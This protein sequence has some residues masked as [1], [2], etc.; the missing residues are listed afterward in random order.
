M[1]QYKNLSPLSLAIVV[2]TALA[3]SNTTKQ[4][5]ETIIP[6]T[7]TSSEFDKYWYAGQAE[8]TR[9]ELEQ[10][11]Y[12]EI[13][14]GD[15]VLIF[16]TEDFD[17]D[18]QVKYEGGKKSKAVKPILKLNFTK[19]FYTG[20]YPYSMMTSIF[21]PINNQPTVKVTTTSQEWCGHTFSQLNLKKNEYKGILHSYFQQ[22]GDQ[23]F[24]L[25]K[26]LLEDEIWSKIRLNPNTLPTGDIEIIPGTQFLRLRH[27]DH[28]VAKAK[29][30]LTD[31][32]DAD[33]SNQ[34]LQ[35]YQI[36]YTDLNRVLKIT[37]EKSFPH[38]IVAWEEEV[39][40]GFGNA[41]KLTTR[42]TRTHTIKSPYWNKHTV[43]DAALRQAL[44]L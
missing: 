27:I 31:F 26:V 44:G 14:K 1:K 17:T 11:R 35:Q 16:V 10:A 3:W 32:A 42:A 23:S 5:Q 41:K 18:K 34:P 40:S 20:L 9:Y 43:A 6:K 36:S 8:L 33:L 30:S 39:L 29:A 37:F 2:I 15:A 28:T 19:K 38:A 25:K 24:A 4:T 21:T 12:G 22:E 13:H 7:T